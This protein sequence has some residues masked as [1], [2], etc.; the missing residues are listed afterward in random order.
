V[1][2]TAALRLGTTAALDLAKQGL[3]VMLVGL[4]VLTGG[5]LLLFLA[6]PIPAGL[7]VLAV[8]VWLVRRMMPLL[9]AAEWPEWARLLRHVLPVAVAT[10]MGILQFRIVMIITSLVATAEET[11]YFAASFRVVEV[12][13]MIPF[14]L[15]GSAFPI[16][17]RAAGGDH[18]RLRYAVQRLFEGGLIAG[19]GIAALLVVGAPVAIDVVAGPRFQES[20]PVLRIQGAALAAVFFTAIWIF[21]AIS[22]H[23][24]RAL[25]AA[26]AVGLAASVALALIL[27]PIHG[28]QGAAVATLGAELALALAYLVVLVRRR[29]DLR[30]TMRILPRVLAAVA[31]ALAI[32]LALGLPALPGTVLAAGLYV[33]LLL[34][35]RAVPAELWEALPGRGGHGANTSS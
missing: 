2:L 14:V 32:P 25:V 7:A 19:T 4:V 8:A 21:A 18:D 34:V 9:P 1:P 6:V 33:A 17:A 5:G 23:A 31:P 10:A 24:H 13:L 29:P 22:L 30:P 3:I 11:G 28:A 12:L 26:S 15:V 35:L 20:V 27:V 16:L